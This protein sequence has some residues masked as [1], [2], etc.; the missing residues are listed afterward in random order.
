MQY[1]ETQKATLEQV[2]QHVR[3][4]YNDMFEKMKAMRDRSRALRIQTIQTRIEA[5]K[6]AK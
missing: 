3:D 5:N 4:Y 6:E 2:P 1:I